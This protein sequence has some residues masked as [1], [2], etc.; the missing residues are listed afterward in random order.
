M[1]NK[2]FYEQ[3][4]TGMNRRLDPDKMGKGNCTLAVNVDLSRLTSVRK[5]KG[6]TLLGDAGISNS[7]VQSLIEYVTTKDNK[8]QRQIQMIRNNSLYFFNS[9]TNTWDL[10]GG[11]STAPFVNNE[12]IQSVLYK[13]RV[14]YTSPNRFLCYN[15]GTSTITDVSPNGNDQDKIKGSCLA[16]GQRTLFIGNVTVNGEYLPTRVYYSWFDLV[17]ANKGPTD[18]L[19]LPEEENLANSSTYFDVEGGYVQNIIS[20]AN[21]NKVYI[22]SDTKCY[23]FD[24]NQVETNP[25]NALQEVFEIGCAG[26]RSAVVVDKCLYW[27]DKQAKI[28]AWN[29]GVDVPIEISYIIDDN[30]AGDSV[31]S[32]IDRSNDN[33]SKVVAFGI[34]KTIYFSVGTINIDNVVIP[35]AVIKLTASQDG[36]AGYLSLDSYPDRL[37]V[38]AIVTVNNNKSLAVG[39][40]QNALL[41]NSGLNDID[42]NNAEVAIN[43]YYRTRHYDFGYSFLDKKINDFAIKFRPQFVEDPNRKI[44]L[45]VKVSID[46]ST[47]YKDLSVV[48]NGVANRGRVELQTNNIK[49]RQK[50]AILYLTNAQ[51]QGLNIGFEFGNSNKDET[52]ELSAFGFNKVTIE[53]N[54][55]R[56]K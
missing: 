37:L 43:S 21:T 20:F 22:F 53:N 52:F 30:N 48:N 24:I 14:Y 11:S 42:L 28:W 46:N 17:S 31:I 50:T 4:F 6:T 10:S 44:Y 36:I 35:N 13:N 29:G 2:S 23:T 5:R 56:I 54:N 34:G 16:V 9:D 38:G 32:Q 7:Q 15:E 49:D 8:E 55:I 33:L 25:F 3:S 26:A 18:Q 39:N 1:E 41:M 47:D 51:A 27:M 45:D 19:W 12:Q 40:S